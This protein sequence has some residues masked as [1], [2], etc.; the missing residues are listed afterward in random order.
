MAESALIFLDIYNFN[1]LKEA[2]LNSSVGESITIKYIRDG[3]EEISEAVI[4]GIH[5]DD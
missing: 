5:P 4:L 1:D 2:I 3:E